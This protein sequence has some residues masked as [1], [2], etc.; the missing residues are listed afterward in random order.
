MVAA[1]HKAHHPLYYDLVGIAGKKYVSDDDFTLE[2]YS[3]DTGPLPANKQ[4]IVVRPADIDEVVDIVKLANTSKI[5]IV[6][7]GGR[8]GYYGTPRGLHGK[9]IVVDMTRMNKMLNVDP[10]NLTATAE[11]G[12][13]TAEYTTHLWDLGWDV[14]TAVQP[15]YSDTLG[16]QLSGFCGGGNGMEMSSVGFNAL[17]V[18]GIKVV[19]PDGTVVQTGAGKGNNIYNTMLYDRYPG[20]P[21]LTGIFM[22]DAGTFGLKVEA[23]YR[24]YKPVPDS[25]RAPR[26]IGFDSYEKA[27]EV[28]QEISL[29]EPLPYYI[30]SIIVPTEFYKTMGMEDM[31]LVLTLSKGASK[32]ELDAKLEILDEV[33]EKHKGVV[34]TGPMV[35]EWVETSSTGQRLRE[36]GQFSS[37]GTFSVFE[38]FCARSQVMECRNTIADLIYD[39]FKE[40][41]IKMP[42]VQEVLVPSLATAWIVSL[43]VHVDGDDKDQQDMMQQL[44]VEA[45]E[46]ACSKG[47]YPD[48]HQGFGTR[49]MA[50]YWPKHHYEF[51]KKLKGALDP[52]NIMNPGI[53]D[54]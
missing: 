50:K 53:W 22:G 37:I 9:G 45:T 39:R 41:G 34:A 3:R 48:C 7:S 33:F 27:W 43:F 12:M 24:L 11:A 10:V 40:V 17:H 23:S 46:L 28:V 25:Q 15:W 2:A 5:P 8:A 29:I 38:Y 21:D 13:T 44:Y 4:G 52:N 42:R 47:W 16:G 54:L 18:A 14:H 35:D 36:M 26:A 31:H 49:M 51:M 19:L 30:I 32:K 1:I 20:N 6:A